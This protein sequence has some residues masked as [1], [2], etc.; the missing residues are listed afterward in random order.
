M[1]IFQEKTFLKQ[2]FFRNLFNKKNPNNALIELNNLLASNKLLSISLEQV[3]DIESRYKLNLKRR[4]KKELMDV[5]QVYLEHCIRDAKITDEELSDLSHLKQLLSL[6]DAD[7]LHIQNKAAGDIYESKYGEV[8]ANGRLTL[9]EETNLETIAK[10]LYLPETIAKQISAE[11]RSK[12]FDEFL[13]SAT[14]DKRLSESESK[15]LELIGKSLCVKFQPDEQTKAV[16]DKFKLLW[17]IENGNLPELGVSINLQK[18]EV[19]YFECYAYWYEH[20][21]VSTRINYGGTTARIK[22]MKGVYYSTGSVK[23]QSVK[24]E[25]LRQIDSGQL[26]LTNKRII[27]VGDKK[28]TNI[29]LDKILEVNPY[30]DSVEIIKDAGKPPT[31]TMGNSEAEIFYMMLGRLIA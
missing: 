4:F 29:K 1:I 14:A 15:E 28:S 27:F 17:V 13:K 12:K 8:V 19:C 21:T 3:S 7:V 2:G 20:R 11:V 24:S 23:V 25:E 16:L 5:Y 26:Y 9:E 6:N 10:N 22:I 30:R 31:L 18:S